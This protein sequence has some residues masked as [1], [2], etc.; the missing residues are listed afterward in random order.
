[1]H[2]RKLRTPDAVQKML[3]LEC[4][5]PTRKMRRES[6]TTACQVNHRASVPDKAAGRA[7]SGWVGPT[8]GRGLAVLGGRGTRR[9]AARRHVG[10][11]RSPL[12]TASWPS[13]AILRVWGSGIGRPL[14]RGR[15]RG[16][17]A[18]TAQPMASV[19]AS[20]H[21]GAGR[22]AQPR[23]WGRARPWWTGSMHQ[24]RGFSKITTGIVVITT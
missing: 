19:R 14:R 10:A 20:H 2:I 6:D 21:V 23:G 13:V 4:W 1:M 22:L 11:H 15:V 12:A 8:H 16:A 24:V 9:P 18:Q 17:H 7:V 3:Q 5:C